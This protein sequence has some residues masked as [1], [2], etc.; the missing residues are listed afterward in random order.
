MIMLKFVRMSLGCLWISLLLSTITGCISL[1]DSLYQH[2]LEHQRHKADLRLNRVTI[3]DHHISYLE[4]GQGPTLILVHGFGANKDNWLRLAPHLVAN[5]HVLIPDLPGHGDSSQD[6][7]LNYDIESQVARLREFSQALKLTQ[8]HLAGN[9]MGGAISLFYSA[10]FPDQVLSLTLID[11]AGVESPRQSELFQQLAE[12][13]N[14][15]I[16]QRPGDLARLAEFV[17]SQPPFVPWPLSAAI[18]RRLLARQVIN[19][20]IFADILGT[21]QRYQSL[22]DPL[23]LL[24]RIQAPVLIIWGEED[25]VLDASSVTVF[26]SALPQAEV[27]VLPAIGHVPMLEAPKQTAALLLDFLSSPQNNPSQDRVSR[28]Q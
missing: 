13:K 10:W 22:T 24:R 12:G 18:E 27:A 23:V 14:P 20:K 9:S 15:L 16:V 5:Y 19:H 4:G 6:L 3:S 25:R 8:F 17:M 21:R 28:H 1:Q 26:V 2:T 11:S 7:N